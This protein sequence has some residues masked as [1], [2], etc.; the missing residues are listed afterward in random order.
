MKSINGFFDEYRFLSNFWPCEVEFDD[1]LYPSVEHAY[2]AAKT[3]SLAARQEIRNCRTPGAAKK[4]GQRI[5]LRPDWEDVRVEI[6][7]RL[8][9]QKFDDPDLMALLAATGDAYLEET[10]TWGD[11]FWGVCKGTGKNM[12]G[13]LLMEVRDHPL[14]I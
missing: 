10:N 6:M 2:Q 9:Y 13:K 11:T 5:D 1:F 3:F 12:L 4:L 14:F 8:L 7:R